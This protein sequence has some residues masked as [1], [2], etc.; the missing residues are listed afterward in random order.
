MTQ[1]K[2]QERPLLERVTESLFEETLK[3]VAT[4]VWE[5]RLGTISKQLDHY[6]LK[7]VVEKQLM[8]VARVVIANDPAIQAGMLQVVSTEL[9]KM[10]PY[11]KP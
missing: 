5:Q 1:P 4:R 11:V 9:R 2:A 8:E 7:A 10:F 6:Q 3:N